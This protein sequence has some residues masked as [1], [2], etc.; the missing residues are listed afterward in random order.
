MVYKRT[1]KGSSEMKDPIKLMQ[2]CEQGIANPDFQPNQPKPG[3]THCN[4]F[5][6]FVAKGM[7]CN[8]LED[9]AHAPIMA[10]SILEMFQINTKNWRPVLD[11]TKN[12]SS[13]GASILAKAGSLVFGIM[14][15]EQLKQSHGHICV[16]I[17]G[18]CKFS[19]EWNKLAPLCANVGKDIFIGKEMAYA[20]KTIPSFYV[21][22]PS[23]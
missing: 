16:V 14:S 21:W 15:S 12:P 2:L 5:A 7:G 20:F 9:H 17:P 1:Y 18:D 3:E 8:D 11:M 4:Q 6:D 10:N 23:I 13:S 19:G 22:I